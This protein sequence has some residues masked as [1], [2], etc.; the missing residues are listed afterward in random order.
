MFLHHSATERGPATPGAKTMAMLSPGKR[1]L[2]RAI[3]SAF[4]LFWLV[5]L[6]GCS[7]GNRFFFSS[8]SEFSA[9]PAY[10]GIPYED[11]W[12]SARDGM[13][14]NGWFAAGAPGFP[15]ILYFHGNGG[16]LSDCAEYLKLLHDLGFPVCVFDYR[17]Y[18]Q[19]HG[20]TLRENDL[21]E[22]AR[23]AIA[24]LEKRGW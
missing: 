5:T 11:V 13:T 9:T 8:K 6:A 24:Y 14:L 3:F 2:G 7:M 19:S 16:N 1:H 22:D 21:Y 4:V 10:Y 15:L 17:G 12:F 18:G 20:E 23:G